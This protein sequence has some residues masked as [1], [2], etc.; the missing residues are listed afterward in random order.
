[1]T[2]S[3]EE[4]GWTVH[5]FWETEILKEIDRCVELIER[6]LQAERGI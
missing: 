1:M 2:R 6:S 4:Q 3:L 5:R